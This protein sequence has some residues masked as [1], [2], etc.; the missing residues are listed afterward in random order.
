MA[1]TWIFQSSLSSSSGSCVFAALLWDAEITRPKV[2]NRSRSLF[3][4][5]W[6]VFWLSL[7]SC[8]MHWDAFHSEFVL[9]LFLRSASWRFASWSCKQHI[10]SAKE[11]LILVSNLVFC[12]V[13]CIW[14]LDSQ[15][16]FCFSDVTHF[17]VKCN[18]LAWDNFRRDLS[19]WFRCFIR[20][21]DVNM[22]PWRTTAIQRW[23]LTLLPRLLHLHCWKRIWI[24]TATTALLALRCKQGFFP[25]HC[26]RKLLIN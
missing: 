25:I 18:M 10:I 12:L 8:F 3:Q 4:L 1:F 24:K 21:L 11:E 15:S 26:D 23:R 13:V 5:T 2:S 16:I 17:Q 19:T 14:I 7:Q 20:L 9:A 22:S 6:T